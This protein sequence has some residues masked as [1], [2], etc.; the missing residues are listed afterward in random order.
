MKSISE[1]SFFNFINSNNK[2]GESSSSSSF[3][4]TISV[5]EVV[6]KK[7]DSEEEKQDSNNSRDYFKELTESIIVNETTEI[8]KTTT[9]LPNKQR[10][11]KRRT[12]NHGSKNRTIQ[13]VENIEYRKGYFVNSRGYKLVCQEW[14]P[15]N[16]KGVVIILHGYG[17]HGQ[18]L[19]ADDCKM[20]AKL[21]YASF[22]FDQQG[23]G[24]SEGLTAYIRDFEDLVEDSMLFISDIKFRFPTLKR[25][26]YCCS[27]GGAVG[28]LVSLKKPEIFN[29]GLIL[30]A[31][32]IKLD[33]NMVPNPLVV[34]I[35]RWVSQ[36]FP[37]LPIVPGDNV[38]DRSIKDPQKRLE[39]A[40]HPLTYKGRARLGTGLAILKVT[41]YLQDHLK[42][43]N[44]PLLICHGSLDRVS[45]PKVS[46]ELYSLAKSKDKT[47]KI[48]QSFWHGLTCEETSYIIY[49]DIT[50]WMKERLN[51]ES[52]FE[53]INETAT[54]Q[55][56]INNNDNNPIGAA[57]F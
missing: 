45:S 32:L 52:N 15:K 25:F 7:I 33:E 1:I 40:T 46:E 22:I 57:S 18:T 37:T 48:Y 49:D 29:G 39:H 19:L 41:S 5:E 43:V 26:V 27:M 28:L 38:L 14:I 2:N 9:K 3:S 16:P 8:I 36:S 21:G 51:K 17:D 47:L 50:N 35:L 53:T 34:S 56:N 4:S 23:H 42:D 12:N 13:V 11:K 24:L 30:L 31:P 6:T 10:K 44:V 55:E 20:F 54:P